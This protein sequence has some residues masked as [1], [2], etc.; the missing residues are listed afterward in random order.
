MSLRSPPGMPGANGSLHVAYGVL[1][2]ADE[3]VVPRPR[4][5]SRRDADE[6]LRGP[7]MARLTSLDAKPIRR[8][9]INDDFH[10]ERLVQAGHGLFR[11][12]LLLCVAQKPRI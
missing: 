2:I 3:I 10:M 1:R 4:P 6:V 11:L 12:V 5:V 8:L 9:R 7:E